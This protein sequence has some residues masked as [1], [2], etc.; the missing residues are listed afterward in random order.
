MSQFYFLKYKFNGY[1]FRKTPLGCT[2]GSCYES[3]KKDELGPIHSKHM[4]TLMHGHMI[5]AIKEAENAPLSAHDLSTLEY[6]VYVSDE[7]APAGAC[8]RAHIHQEQIALSKSWQES[9]EREARRSAMND[10]PVAGGD[11]LYGALGRDAVE[12]DSPRD[13]ASLGAPKLA[14]A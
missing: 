14:A 9:I 3:A 2:E 5:R 8:H 11:P 6:E 7:P 4:L 13:M 10:N 1:D 12:E